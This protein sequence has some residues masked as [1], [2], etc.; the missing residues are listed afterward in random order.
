MQGGVKAEPL[1]P[2]Q[3]E[4]EQKGAPPLLLPIRY[5]VCC[6]R[7]PFLVQFTLFMCSLKFERVHKEVQKCKHSVIARD[8]EGDAGGGVGVQRCWSR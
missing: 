8:V 7:S 3:L 1:H 4:D 2:S 6:S 5:A